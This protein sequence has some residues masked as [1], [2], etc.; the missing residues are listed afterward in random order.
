MDK[1]IFLGYF[2][3]SK[4]YRVFNTRTLVIVEYIHV[5]LNDGLMP[6]RKLLDLEDDFAYM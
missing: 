3:T 1:G 5:K 4:A 6:D 2:D